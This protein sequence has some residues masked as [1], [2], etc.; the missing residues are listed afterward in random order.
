MTSLGKRLILT[1][2]SVPALFSLI[3]FLP[4]YHHLGFAIL[5]VLAVFSGSYEMRGMLF[6]SDEKPLVPYWTPV[7]LPAMQFIE[8]VYMP[9]IP[10]LDITFVLLLIAGFAKEIFVG[11]KDDFSSTID[12][13]GRTVFLLI[14]PGYF[15]IF[16]I[17]ILLH[18]QST[19][20]LLMLFLLVFGND[21]FA[22]VFGMWLGKKNRNIVAVSPNKS[23][24]GFIGGIL[25]TMLLSLLW[26][27]FIPSMRSMF[28][29][30]EALLIGFLL[31]IVSDIGDLV[32]SAFK[33]GAKVKDS[34]TIIFGRGGILDSIDSLLASAPFFIVLVA[35]LS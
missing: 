32:E 31:A 1:F 10:I 28:S 11:A 9:T 33:R 20:L 34:G 13:V 29:L 14:Y 24:A 5:T 19:N 21:T 35:L 23:I 4:H 27:R 6:R 18:Q 25:S 16:L 17:R 3:Y 26:V 30:G 7:L 15:S 22:Y 12:R 8:S 2:T